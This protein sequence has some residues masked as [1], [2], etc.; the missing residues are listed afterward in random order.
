MGKASSAK[1]VARAARA[2]GAT[3]NKTKRRLA[4][5]VGIAAIVIVGSAI[6]FFARD[7]STST[8]TVPL[9]ITSSSIVSPDGA[10]TETLPIDTLP[11]ETLP[12]DA[13]PTSSP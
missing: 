1:K 7:S 10:S 4:F 13:T 9:D 3:T 2:G 5:P 8:P 11:V 6:I 12:P